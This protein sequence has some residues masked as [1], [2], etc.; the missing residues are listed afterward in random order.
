MAEKLAL[1]VPEVTPAV[2]TAGYRVVF[3]LLAWEQQTITIHLR[4]DNGEL[5]EFRYGGPLPQTAPA[6]RAKALALMTA[7]NKA[8]LSTKS[9]QRRILEQLLADGLLAGTVAGVPD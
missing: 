5:R 9:L 6:E 4:G 1:A 8:N 7:L 3:L 2:S